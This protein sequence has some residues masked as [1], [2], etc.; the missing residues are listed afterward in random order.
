MPFKT[1]HL[2]T[3]CNLSNSPPNSIPRGRGGF[4]HKKSGKKCII[5]PNRFVDTMIPYTHTH[6][7]T[8]THA[9]THT[10]TNK[11]LSVVVHITRIISLTCNAALEAKHL[12][13]YLSLHTLF[14]FGCLCLVLRLRELFSPAS[15]L[16]TTS[17][18][19]CNHPSVNQSNFLTT[20]RGSL[21]QK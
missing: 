10:Q 8:R 21:F 4:G 5:R 16:Q 2:Y 1:P 20:K 7:H 3:P 17:R 15:F 6:A 19:S 12:F 18:P 14:F 11:F 9:H 13:R